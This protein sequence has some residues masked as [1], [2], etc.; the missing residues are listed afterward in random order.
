MD[1][2]D[3]IVRISDEDMQRQEKES[4]REMRV[5]KCYT[6][7]HTWKAMSSAKAGRGLPL[8]FTCTLGEE[9]ILS[10]DMNHTVL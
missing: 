2:H 6:T 4:K 8:E 3:A 10:I 7:N 5:S 1:K 9:V